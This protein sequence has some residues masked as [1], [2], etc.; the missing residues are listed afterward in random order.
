MLAATRRLVQVSPPTNKEG[1][2]AV[3]EP[4]V[5]VLFFI[6]LPRFR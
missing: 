1:S 5:F 4:F 3:R 6:L 2:L